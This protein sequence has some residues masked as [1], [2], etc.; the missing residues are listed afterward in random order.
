MK[1]TKQFGELQFIVLFSL[2]NSKTRLSTNLFKNWEKKK[3]GV[4][5]HLFFKNI[6]C[7]W[8]FHKGTQYRCKKVT[9]LRCLPHKLWKPQNRGMKNSDAIEFSFNTWKLIFLSHTDI[10]VNAH[11]ITPVICIVLQYS[12][13]V[14]DFQKRIKIMP[15]LAL[16]LQNIAQ[17]W[18]TQSKLIKPSFFCKGRINVHWPYYTNDLPG[19]L[20]K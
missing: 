10:Y 2:T 14:I 18:E 15:Q 19:N 7:K 20:G 1:P 6:L 16:Y 4:K 8:L 11:L 13:S 5:L 9:P 3:R 17:E 12:T